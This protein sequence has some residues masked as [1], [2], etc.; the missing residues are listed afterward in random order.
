MFDIELDNTASSKRQ[1]PNG[2][3]RGGG[4]NS[5]RSTKDAKYGFGG[6]KRFAKSNDAASAGEMKGFSTERMKGRAPAGKARA[7]KVGKSRPG[8]SK[9]AKGRL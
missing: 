8:K 3:S 1:K 5:K 6:K 4:G 2:D 9:R 7:G